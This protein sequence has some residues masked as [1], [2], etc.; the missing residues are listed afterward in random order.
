MAYVVLSSGDLEVGSLSSGNEH[1]LCWM[2]I[3]LTWDF[4]IRFLVQCVGDV[5]VLSWKVDSIVSG[6]IYCSPGAGPRVCRLCSWCLTDVF[7]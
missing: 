2:C 6:I 3:L 5:E 4:A 7:R 1:L